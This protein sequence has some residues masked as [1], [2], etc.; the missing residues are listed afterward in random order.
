MAFYEQMQGIS[1]DLLTRFNQGVIQLVQITPGSGPTHNPGPSVRGAPIL[2]KG[3]A[4]AAFSV[5][6]ATKTYQNGTT[7]Q[8]G[9]VKVVSKVI[10]N[11]DPKLTDKII[12]DGKEYGIIQFNRI[13]ETG[14]TVA[15]IFYVRRS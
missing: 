7:I 1:T 11:I 6:G 14:T 10:A 3:S 15:W 4:S 5:R 2:L 12:L 8:A 13:P 9:D